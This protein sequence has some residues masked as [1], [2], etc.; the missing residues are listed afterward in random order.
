MA[1]IKRF[2]ELEVWQLARLQCSIIWDLINEG[3]FKAD[4][5][6]ADQINRSSG[7]V[8][9]NISEG[10]DRSSKAEFKQAL[11]VARGSNA[12]V[13]SQL[14]RAVDRNWIL[15]PDADKWTEENARIGIKLHNLIQYLARSSY[16]QKPSSSGFNG[17]VAENLS[18]PELPYFEFIGYELAPDFLCKAG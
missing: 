1:T 10:F 8:M 4:K 3:H 6:L 16:K 13:R 18:E 7:S 15:K 12:E 9:D 14:Y 2:E 17:T 11:I 5:P